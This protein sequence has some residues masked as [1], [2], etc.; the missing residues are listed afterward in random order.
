MIEAGVSRSYASID[1]TTA[2]LARI[3]TAPLGGVVNE[4]IERGL[5]AKA[6]LG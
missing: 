2:A 4:P 1:Q 6:A 5:R 3:G